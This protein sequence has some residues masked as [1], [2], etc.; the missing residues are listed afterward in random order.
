M[1]RTT[2][3]S[4]GSPRRRVRA[5][6]SLS[7][8][9]LAVLL[10]EGIPWSAGTAVAT[11]GSA[12]ASV[13]IQYLGPYQ[14]NVALGLTDANGSALRSAI[15]GNFT[16]FVDTLPINS[17]T[18]S[19]ILAMI[20]TSEQNPFLAGFFGNRDGRVEAGEVTQFESLLANGLK[21]VPSSS[22]LNPTFVRVSLDGANPTSSL[23]GAFGFPGAV[24]ADSSAA[25]LEIEVNVTDGFAS[26]TS[27]SAH[28]IG[29]GWS[30]PAGLGLIVNPTIQFTAQTPAATAIKGTTGLTGVSVRNDIWGWGTSSASGTFDPAT[31][32]NVTV[33]FENA[34]PVGD[35]LIATAVVA[36]ILAVGVVWVIRRYRRARAAGHP[37]SS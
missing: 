25:P 23:V 28:T 8:A 37:P 10:A 4:S 12:S 24:G 34:F 1:P 6:R 13:T 16:P 27:G 22:F 18:R 7:L 20:N 33:S 11:A 26:A 31:S 17:S 14:L 36:P 2:S 15:D 32:G 30:A 35:L 3:F 21:L 5:R 9:V 29:L 19:S